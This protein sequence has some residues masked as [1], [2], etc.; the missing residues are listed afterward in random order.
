MTYFVSSET[1]KPEV[2]INQSVNTAFTTRGKD[3]CQSQQAVSRDIAEHFTASTADGCAK[4]AY[5][6]FRLQSAANNKCD[7]ANPYALNTEYKAISL[8]VKNK[9]LTFCSSIYIDHIV[10]H[11]KCNHQAASVVSNF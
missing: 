8:S 9:S 2:S 5:V 1:L 4:L 10:L 11:A 3:T 7:A 6:S